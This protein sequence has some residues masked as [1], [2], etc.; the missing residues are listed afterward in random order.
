MSH[1]PLRFERRE[2]DNMRERAQSFWELMRTRR[3]VRAFSDR[4]VSREIIEF[5]IRTAGGAPNGANQQPWHFAV[6]SDQGIKRA[7]REAA[8][9]E[10][11]AFYGGRAPQAWLDALAPL[12]TD[13]SKPFLDIA[14]Y[15]IGIFAQPH[16]IG[17]D[18]SPLKHYYVQESVGI[19]AGFLI[20]ALH[21]AGLATLTHTPSPMGFLNTIMK[22]PQ[23]ERAFLL[24]VVGHPAD[25]ATV[26]VITKKPLEEIASFFGE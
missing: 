7:I 2:A 5:A 22:R 21:Q 19:A 26:P 15:L 12:G 11:R 14:P 6:V 1:E 25:D 8:E 18:G 20:A 17:P 24:L 4:P 23:H 10:E 3:S 9:A 16:G 13:A